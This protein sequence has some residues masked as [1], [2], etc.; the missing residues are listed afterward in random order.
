MAVFWLS[1][2]LKE[3]PA[4]LVDMD[5]VQGVVAQKNEDITSRKAVFL[6]SPKL[7]FRA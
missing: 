5:T 2:C 3:T 1:G 7:R 4:K 6:A